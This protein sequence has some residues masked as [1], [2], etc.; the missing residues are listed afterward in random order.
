M[1]LSVE[2]QHALIALEQFALQA[3][4]PILY[5]TPQGVDQVGT[6]TLLTLANRYFIV[7]AAHIFNGRDPGRFAIPKGRADADLHTLGPYQL[8]KANEAE[9]DI[10]ILELYEQSTIKSA[11][12]GWH[13]LTL[14]NIGTA[15]AAGVF[16]LCGYPSQKAWRSKDVIGGKPITVFTERISQPVNANAPVHS[17]LDLFFHY[18]IDAPNIDGETVVT[19]HLGGASGASV[20]EY[21]APVPGSLWSPEQTLRA[22]GVQSAFLHKEY[23]R[24]KSWDMVL[25]ML[26]QADPTL[27][28]VIDSHLRLVIQP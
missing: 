4:I 18:G 12:I 16:I 8:Y 25:Q 13:I 7:T 3:T 17:A 2:D 6:G 5:D 28:V 1:V 19:A 26:R 11:E 20:W 21:R 27:G 14:E 10:A 23:F 24:A 22:V 15:S 9:I